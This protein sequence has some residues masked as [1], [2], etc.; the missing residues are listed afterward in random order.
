MDG[1]DPTP[2]IF[3]TL[4]YYEIVSNVYVDVDLNK[5]TY[6]TRM[7]KLPV[8]IFFMRIRE[9]GLSFIVVPANWTD[10]RVYI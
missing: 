1:L 6:N 4:Y 9:K 2:K 8:F 7:L 10:E 3:I 5:H